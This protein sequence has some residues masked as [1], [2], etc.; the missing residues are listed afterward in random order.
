[1][2]AAEFCRGSWLELVGVWLLVGYI[3]LIFEAYFG[4]FDRGNP[5]HWNRVTLGIGRQV[6][7]EWDL[8]KDHMSREEFV[9]G[10]EWPVNGKSSEQ[11]HHVAGGGILLGVIGPDNKMG[12]EDDR[13]LYLPLNPNPTQPAY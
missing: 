4:S 9:T 12:T 5:Q 10:R 8:A 1:M 13:V 2:K 6:S 11:F 3:H 7:G